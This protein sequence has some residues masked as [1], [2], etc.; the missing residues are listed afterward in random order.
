MQFNEMMYKLA[1]Y[2]FRYK[3][4]AP[5]R[6][7]HNIAMWQIGCN[8]HKIKPHTTQ[9]IIIQRFTLH[10]TTTRCRT[11]LRYAEL[12]YV[13]CLTSRVHSHLRLHTHTR[14]CNYNN[15]ERKSIV[16]HYIT[17][18]STTSLYYTIIT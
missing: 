2:Q 5:S 18:H 16:L 17:T 10:Y 11:A 12:R 8:Q 4:K 6:F 7:A 1:L 3:H 14:T 13:T 15:H 9:Y